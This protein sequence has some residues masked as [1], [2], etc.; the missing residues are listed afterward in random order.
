MSVE[1][2]LVQIAEKLQD[3]KMVAKAGVIASDYIRNH[4]YSGAF[5]PLSPATIDYR[6]SGK[7]LQDTGSLR[8]SIT[9]ELVNGQTVSVGT[10]KIYA[11]IQNNGGTITAKKDWL[12]IPGPRMRYYQRKYGYKVGEVLKGLKSEGFSVFRMG[13]T[14]VYKK[15]GRKAKTHVA[16]YLKKSVVIPARRFFELTEDEK[17]TILQECTDDIL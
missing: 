14:V 10:T 5:E 9:S 17:T 2:E 16:F 3:T 15:S 13:R 11:P 8:D 4:I 6:G 1:D 12:W 7:P